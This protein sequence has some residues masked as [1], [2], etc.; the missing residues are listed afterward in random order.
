VS[1]KW[2]GLDL[3]VGL[4]GLDRFCELTSLV[5]SQKRGNKL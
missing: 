3:W 4:T 2:P 1:S 5:C